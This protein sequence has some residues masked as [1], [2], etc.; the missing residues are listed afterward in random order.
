MST[1]AKQNGATAVI[2]ALSLFVMMNTAAILNPVL[3]Y[4]AE[5]NFPDLPFS[6]VTYLVTILSLMVIPCSLISGAIAGKKIG[7]KPLAVISLVLLAIGG[8]LPY[9]NPT[10]F[11]YVLASRVLVGIGVGFYVPLGN[12]AALRLFTDSKARNVL[13]IGQVVT[14]VMGM[15]FQA[16]ATALVISD[17]NYVWFV[18]LIALIP[19]LLI[20]FF[21]PEPEKLDDAADAQDESATQKTR[22][23]GAIWAMGLM[24]LL[25]FAVSYG[26][27][28]NVSA[29][30]TGEGLGD[31]GQIL[32][33]TMAYTLGGLIAGFGFNKF[34]ELTG[35]KFT[36][37]TVALW[38]IGAAVFAFGYNI[39]LLT[40]GSFI[41][42]AAIFFIMPGTMTWF[43]NCFGVRHITFASAV[44]QASIGI[45]GFLATPWIT[46]IGNVT[47][48]P[49]PRLPIMI[50]IVVMIAVSI[51][52][53][54]YT[55]SKEKTAANDAQ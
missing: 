20:L 51:W 36:L 23:P 52:W 49:D 42:G 46:T 4:V 2:G 26:V 33:V 5:T 18:H 13:G 12:A 19:A 45:G 37:C 47:G 44:M 43:T 48:N 34:F 16:I 9:F 54:I 40:I 53:T 24:F 35:K 32:I 39:P 22:T 11:A 6:T 17:V 21:L 38:T 8:V 15:A 10:N 28:F 41:C 7:F 29:I 3:S 31:A 1:Q 30:V 50:G 55:G 25:M 14:S 27:T